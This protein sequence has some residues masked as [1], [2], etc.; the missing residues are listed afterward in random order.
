MEFR[1]QFFI[2]LV[3]M[4]LIPITLRAQT[5]SPESIFQVLSSRSADLPELAKRFRLDEEEPARQCSDASEVSKKLL[6]D[7]QSQSVVAV[8]FYSS[9]C[10]KQFAIIFAGN[11]DVWTYS[12]TRVLEERYA[13]PEYNAAV[14]FAGQMPVIVVT[15]NTIDSGTGVSQQNT[16]VF[17]FIGESLQ[18]VFDEPQRVSLAVPFRPK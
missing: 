4:F 13:K 1:L 16:Q 2:C 5:T 7:G 14:L 11:S 9:T 3:G 18:L 10:L 15:N 8:E 12:G 6:W 17:A